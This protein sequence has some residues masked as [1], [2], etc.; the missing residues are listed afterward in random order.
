[1]NLGPR[2]IILGTRSYHLNKKKLKYYVRTNR[3]N[4]KCMIHV[5]IYIYMCDT[6]V[7]MYDTKSETTLRYVYVK[8]TVYVFN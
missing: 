2:I 1:M 4:L 6:C 8:H 7:Y 3:T 5:Y